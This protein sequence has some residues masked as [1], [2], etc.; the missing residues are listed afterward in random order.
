ME[1]RVDDRKLA[2]MADRLADDR[3]DVSVV[4]LLAN[5]TIDRP[6]E[7]RPERLSGI[8][9][10]EAALTQSII[11][12]SSGGMTWPPVAAVALETVV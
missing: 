5:Q 6:P 8:S 1:R 10:S 9:R 3:G 4:H 7:P 2:R 11:P 12:S